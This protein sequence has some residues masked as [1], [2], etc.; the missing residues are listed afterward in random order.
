MASFRARDVLESSAQERA[1]A[2]SLHL[3]ELAFTQMLDRLR[4]TPRTINVSA[5]YPNDVS[6]LSPL[7]GLA[8]ASIE[9]GGSAYSTSS[10]AHSPSVLAFPDLSRKQAEDR[11]MRSGLTLAESNLSRGSSFVGLDDRQLT[12]M[13]AM[14][15]E[16]IELRTVADTANTTAARLDEANR[17]VLTAQE[18]VTQLRARSLQLETQLAA[19]KHADEAKDQHIKQLDL[20]LS[21]HNRADEDLARL[22]RQLAD[23]EQQLRECT[24]AKSAAER[25][26]SSDLEDNSIALHTCAKLRAEINRLTEQ[27]EKAQ[28]DA[29]AA[30]NQLARVQIDLEGAMARMKEVESSDAKHGAILQERDTLAIMLRETQS[31]LEHKVRECRSHAVQVADLQNKMCMFERETAGLRVDME[32]FDRAV[33]REVLRYH[34]TLSERND[35]LS[36]EV[37]KLEATLQQATEEEARQKA[38]HGNVS[39]QQAAITELRSH[40]ES[41]KSNLCVSETL[42]L[43]KDRTIADQQARWAS[44]EEECLLL[45][46]ALDDSAAAVDEVVAARNRIAGEAVSAQKKLRMEHEAQLQLLHANHEAQLQSLHANHEGQLSD[47]R[48]TLRQREI[49]LESSR[50]QRACLQR[51]LEQQLLTLQSEHSKHTAEL[52]LGAQSKIAM[53]TEQLNSLSAKYDSLASTDCETVLNLSTELQDCR[54]IIEQERE[55]VTAVRKG[56]ESE[57]SEMLMQLMAEHASEMQYVKQGFEHHL[58]RLQSDVQQSQIDC[59][60]LL[61]ELEAERS[62]HE[63]TRK[64]LEQ[65]LEQAVRQVEQQQQLELQQTITK[66]K[67]QDQNERFTERSQAQQQLEARL[68]EQTRRHEAE[69]ESLRLGWLEQTRQVQDLLQ[70]IA[71]L[72]AQ[73]SEHIKRESEAK[74]T[75]RELNESVHRLRTQS[76]TIAAENHELSAVL[77]NVKRELESSSAVNIELSKSLDAAQAKAAQLDEQ[78]KNVSDSLKREQLAKSELQL[79]LVQDATDIKG[80]E[81]SMRQLEAMLSEA[82][83]RATSATEEAEQAA[84]I[85]SEMKNREHEFV[86]ELEHY[87]HELEARLRHCAESDATSTALHLKVQELERLHAEEKANLNESS[88]RQ[89]ELLRTEVDRLSRELHASQSR[90]ADD[91]D[92]LFRLRE[93]VCAKEA[94]A[95]SASQHANDAKTEAIQFEGLLMQYQRERDSAVHEMMQKADL[96][97]ELTTHLASLQTEL[98]NHMSSTSPLRHAH[99]EAQLLRAELDQQRAEAAEREAAMEQAVHDLLRSTS[100]AEERAITREAELSNRVAE[101]ELRLQAAT[102]AQAQTKP[103]DE[104]RYG[105]LC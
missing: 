86:L 104:S 53:L 77:E 92:E 2:D 33:E 72:Q 73:S 59:E 65:N 20:E 87:R 60:R 13:A 82:R 99:T 98:N 55:N 29:A 19:V 14:H 25:K 93:L 8:N 105:R 42:L 61:G 26:V 50:E 1:R 90:E 46:T 88:R 6:Y 38:A 49:D 31:Q 27:L 7:A 43:A 85:V 76:A 28:S 67:L 3:R 54:A 58:Q 36:A 70:T 74:A 22:R 71:S 52:E 97:N 96:V 69:M 64:Q 21:R 94:V 95:I 81:E 39:N 51:S 103:A 79:T 16:L 9:N 78:H 4:S 63:T 48:Q 32:E 102:E 40:L 23:V 75:V 12:E 66:Q 83:G 30:S 80:Y 47:L 37:Q 68:A 91:N 5:I 101:L 41:L 62:T 18:E 35:A 100:E 89:I 57:T 24:A 17:I 10:A 11:G 15:R 56:V 84:S 45:R 44:C 34:T